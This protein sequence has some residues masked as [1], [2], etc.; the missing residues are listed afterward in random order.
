MIE[1][2]RIR[3]LPDGRVSLADAAA[4]LGYQPKT[5]HE[6]RRVG[7]G[8]KSHLVGSRR[9]FFINDLRDFASSGTR[10]AVK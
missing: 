10:G 9:F 4:F 8:P 2:V 1:D 3:V 6:F 7:R 5:L